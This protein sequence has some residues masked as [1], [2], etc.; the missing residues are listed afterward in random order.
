VSDS[1]QFHFQTFSMQQSPVGQRI[2]TDAV[3][4]GHII[5]SASRPSHALD[6]GA[7][8]GV[9]SFMLASHFKTTLITAIE[10]EKT[11]FH[12]LAQT[13]TQEI[14][15]NRVTPVNCNL[16]SYLKRPQIFDLIMCNPPFFDNGP[17][18]KNESRAMARHQHTL[19]VES[20]ASE[21]KNLLQKDGVFFLLAPHQSSRSWIDVFVRNG[22]NPVQVIELLDK[23][24]A[25][26]HA[27][28]IMFYKQLTV[29]TQL[30]SIIYRNDVGV[31]TADFLEIQKKW[32]RTKNPKKN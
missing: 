5:T 14:W 31:Y 25:N 18:A 29:N 4:F 15:K 6:I 11:A 7:G 10:P 22:L 13:A 20:L 16:A 21:A 2:T 8:S 23:P 19:Q 26:P 24:R 9:L 30:K 28:V 12:C 27:S 17:S 3:V 1:E 32:L